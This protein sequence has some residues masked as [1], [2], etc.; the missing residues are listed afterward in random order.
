M[1]EARRL[2]LID[3][4]SLIHRAFH[5]LPPLTDRSGHPI[6][7]IYGLSSILI[8]ILKEEKPDYAAGLFDRPEPTFRK[9]RYEA[10]KAHRPPTPD[11]LVRQI[12]EARET[13]LNF[14]I[15]VIECPGFEADDLIGTLAKKF[16]SEPDLSIVILTGDMDTLQLVS[17]TVSVRTLKKGVGETSLFDEAAVVERCGV[18][19][20]QIVDY[21]ALL[22]DPSDNIPG[23]K[24]IG[25]KTASELLRKFGNLE[26]IWENLGS[27][28]SQEKK[29]RD[30]KS[31]A[32]LSRE[33]AALRY[34]APT[35]IETLEELAFG[36]NIE[37]ISSYFEAKGFETLIKRLKEDSS[38]TQKR[39][40][41][42]TSFF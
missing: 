41:R 28:G 10:Y 18:S 20:S 30:G 12:I 34:D 31:D 5:A 33:L 29:L 14:G 36:K 42:Q 32:E 4:N 11:D 38:V 25:P 17:P 37:R 27:V 21:K 6:Q 23:V 2:L 19:P 7:A 35:G 8:K 9:K 39:Q 1:T 24:G 13:F 22:G 40:S 15:K 3:A 16:S 26:G